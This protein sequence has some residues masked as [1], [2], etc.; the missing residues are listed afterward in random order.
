MQCI[1]ISKAETFGGIPFIVD[2]FS[3]YMFIAA[4]NYQ[5]KYQVFIKL[6]GMADSQNMLV[7]L[8]SY[9]LKITKRTVIKQ[10]NKEFIFQKIKS[11]LNKILP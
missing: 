9:L 8:Q 4:I 7:T 3:Q 5:W 6:L 1:K 2:A 10:V 11:K